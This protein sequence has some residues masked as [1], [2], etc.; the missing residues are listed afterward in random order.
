MYQCSILSLCFMQFSF[1][2]ATYEWTT[3]PLQALN[4]IIR[5]IYIANFAIFKIATFLI[6]PFTLALREFLG[7]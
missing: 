7:W 2:A 1:P 4:F 5:R 3:C 6:L